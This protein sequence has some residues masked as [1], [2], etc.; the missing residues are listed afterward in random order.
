MFT[1]LGY[2]SNKGLRGALV[3]VLGATL[4][5]LAA[6]ALVVASGTAAGQQQGQESSAQPWGAPQPEQSTQ[7]DFALAERVVG[8]NEGVT[9][10]TQG[11]EQAAQASGGRVVDRLDDPKNRAV[12][13]KFPTEQAA[14][15]AQDGLAK[16]PD[17]QYVER[18]GIVEATGV[19]SDPLVGFQW[20]HTVIR[21][22]ANL[23]TLPSAPPTIA[24]V[25]SGVDYNHP[26]LAGK[27]IK[28]PDFVNKDFDPMDDI[29]NS[30]GTHVAGVA[31]ATA[32]NGQFGEG[33]SPNSKIL[34]IKVLSADNFSYDFDVVQGLAY[35]R[36]ANTTPET[37]VIN[38]SLCA[39]LAQNA[40]EGPQVLRDEV[41]AIKAAGKILV[42]SAGNENSSPDNDGCTYPGNDPN[43][44]LRV[45]ATEEHDCRT[46]FSNFSP[47]SNPTFY[48]IAAPGWNILSL[49]R[50]NGYGYASGTS[51]AAPMVAGAAALVWGKTPSLTR[52]Q[53]VNK[54]VSTGETTSCGFAAPTPRLDVRKALLGTSETAIVGQ[55]L[56][57]ETGEAPGFGTPPATAKL[58]SGDTLLKSDA[59]NESGFYEMTGLRAGT[60]RTLKATRSGSVKGTLRKGISIVNGQVAGAS[61]DALPQARDTGNATVTIDWKTWQ[62]GFL[63]ET[64]ECMDSCNGWEFDLRVKLPDSNIVEPPAGSLTSAPFVYAPKYSSSLPTR[65]SDPVETVIIGS[66]AANGTYKVIANKPPDL[67]PAGGEWNPSWNGSQASVQMYNGAASLGGGLKAVPSTCG[68]NQFWYVG[69]L[70]KSGTSYTWTNKNKNFCTNIAP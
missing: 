39:D 42:A 14:Q 47:A 31:A 22:T 15:A 4:A 48:N 55:L 51:S 70:T 11:L 40:P 33:V 13:L 8:F 3:V 46:L 37:K 30:H 63:P 62:P 7:R 49:T 43:T 27:V 16:R 64:L 50:N 20:H 1:N 66:Q 28:G 57:P 65:T 34:A 32:A 67:S 29:P 26:D 21:K 5:A 25:D 68:T 58:F 2:V 59:T 61:T 10:S 53:V 54:L 6:I 36:T 23:G 52:E 17:V 41:A 38:T 9:N 35:A 19:S 12:L 69:D 45:T 18:N 24:V 56:D 44:A 60:G